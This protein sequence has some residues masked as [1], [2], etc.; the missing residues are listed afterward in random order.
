MHA[1]EGE[2]NNEREMCVL[3]F[4]DNFQNSLDCSLA[5]ET[6]SSQN[7][8]WTRHSGFEGLVKFCSVEKL[9]KERKEKSKIMVEI[10]EQFVFV[11]CLFCCCS[12]C[13]KSFQRSRVF[14]SFNHKLQK[15]DRKLENF[16]KHKQQW[17]KTKKKKE[18]FVNLL[19]EDRKAAL[20]NRLWNKFFF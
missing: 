19:L 9:V 5:L 10:V 4:G 18:M 8:L 6:N 20:H 12:C 15:S 7:E 14:V 17:T 2:S 1:G 11:L 13:F 16:K 3:G